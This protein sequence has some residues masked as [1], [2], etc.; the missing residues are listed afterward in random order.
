[1]ARLDLSTV[2]LTNITQKDVNLFRAILPNL[3]LMSNN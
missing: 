3:T 2:N 1:L